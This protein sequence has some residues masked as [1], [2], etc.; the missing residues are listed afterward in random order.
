MVRQETDYINL[1]L[2]Q[3]PLVSVIIPLFNAEAHIA[4]TL[5]NVLKQTYSPIEIIVVD[6]GSIDSSLKIART[7]ECERVIIHSQ[8]NSG[9]SAARN[10][11]LREAKGDFIQFLDADDL[12][13]ENKIKDQVDILKTDLTKVSF[14]NTVHFFDGE[15]YNNAT[16][17]KN[18]LP[19]LI[20]YENPV[21]LLMN[22]YSGNWKWGMIT[23]HSWLT[24]ANLIKKAGTWNETLTVDDDGEFFCRVLLSSSGVRFSKNV[25][26]YYRKYNNKKSLA[27]MKSDKALKSAFN[28]IQ[29]KERT[30][31][32]KIAPQIWQKAISWQY[33][34][35][36]VIT[37]PYYKEITNEALF[38][39]QNFGFKHKAPVLGGIITETIKLILGWKAAKLFLKFRLK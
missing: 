15:D 2:S 19:Y 17:N 13:S 23:I 3:N 37:Y 12:L 7:F 4:E 11:G 39:V 21:D 29:L 14:C 32:E 20:D 9:A 24:P 22:L 5:Q 38:K 28:A 35:M 25:T 34:Q 8:P 30:L 10:Y 27:S 16:L 26:N 36:A 1:P 18:D 33:F 6:D 31:S